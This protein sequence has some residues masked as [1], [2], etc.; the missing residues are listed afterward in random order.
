MLISTVIINLDGSLFFTA[1][2]CKLVW[3]G[4]KSL[5]DTRSSLGNGEVHFAYIL[6]SSD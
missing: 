1:Y 4:L 5:L 3:R 2:D 6:E